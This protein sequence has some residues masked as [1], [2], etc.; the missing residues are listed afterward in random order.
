MHVIEHGNS[1][2][3]NKDGTIKASFIIVGPALA[4]QVLGTYRENY[5]KFR[6]S[7]AE[8]LARDMR[9]G[10]WL[11]GSKIS[12]IKNDE[13]EDEIA[14]GQHRFAS[15]IES[16]TEQEFLVVT[17][18]PKESYNVEDTNLPR[19]YGDLLRHRGYSGNIR[20]ALVKLI[21]KVE[22]GPGID[23][24]KR[25]TNNEL[26]ITHDKYVDTISRAVS[27]AA[28][29]KRKW[30]TETLTAYAWWSLSEID[31]ERAYTFLISV[32]EGENLR[33]GMPAYSLRE[34]L[35]AEWEGKNVLPRIEYM[36]LI[37]DAWNYYVLGHY[38]SKRLRAYVTL[39]EDN[40]AGLRTPLKFAETTPVDPNDYVEKVLD[41]ITG[42]ERKGE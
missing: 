40:V 10:F 39:K 36:N 6:P 41:E 34:R 9:N 27:M 19:N 26:D 2:A 4:E 5:R 30:L 18:L 25:F 38:V 29:S 13:G 31:R 28:T 24:T 7:Y 21:H 23:T 1:V 22:N 14:D 15:L 8:G 12:F 37:Y 20:P 32:F 3:T 11:P 35:Q 16:G 42:M 17:G 33:Q